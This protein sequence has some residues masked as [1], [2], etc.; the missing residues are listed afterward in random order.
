MGA[1]LARKRKQKPR[2][3]RQP[4]VEVPRVVITERRDGFGVDVLTERR[5][6]L[7]VTRC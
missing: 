5:P 7:R 3:R 6:P 1:V 2:G 4:V